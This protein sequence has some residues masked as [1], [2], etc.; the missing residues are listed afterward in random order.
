[1]KQLFATLLLVL[2]MPLVAGAQ[3]RLSVDEQSVQAAGGKKMT[4]ERS[5]YLTADGRLVVEQ[6]RPQ[7]TIALSN[8][9]GEMRIYDTASNEKNIEMKY[10]IQCV[11]V[12]I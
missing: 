6:L 2:A 5:L 11:N 9:L 1:M 3:V 7:H 12:I 4:S 8:T 10:Y